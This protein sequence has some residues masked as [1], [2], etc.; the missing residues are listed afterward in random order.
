MLSPDYLRLFISNEEHCFDRKNS[1]T[2]V[3]G[4]ARIW[5][6]KETTDPDGFWSKNTFVRSAPLGRLVRVRSRLGKPFRWS[7]SPH[8]S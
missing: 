4:G 3:H 8:S 6:L 1:P 5:S 2:V 7:L